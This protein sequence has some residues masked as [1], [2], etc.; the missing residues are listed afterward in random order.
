MTCHPASRLS[1]IGRASASVVF[2]GRAAAH[3]PIAAASAAASAVE[4]LHAVEVLG[5]DLRLIDLRLIE[6]R[7]IDPVLIAGVEVLVPGAQVRVLGG[8]GAGEL[9]L[10]AGPAVQVRAQIFVVAGVPELVLVTGIQVA[11]LE[12]QVAALLEI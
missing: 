8:A 7:L 11:L 6:L 10:G 4:G 2:W 5:V 3:G 1:L 12:V 9:V